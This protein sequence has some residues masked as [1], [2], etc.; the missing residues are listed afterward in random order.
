VHPI[1]EQHE[2][3]H[4]DDRKQG[5]IFGLDHKQSHDVVCLKLPVF[6]SPQRRGAVLPVLPE[7][8]FQPTSLTFVMDW[9]Q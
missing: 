7:Y 5:V 3:D 6:G 4:E 9:N 1:E 2:V 8:S